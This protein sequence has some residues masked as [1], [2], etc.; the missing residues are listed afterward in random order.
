MIRHEILNQMANQRHLRRLL[1]PRLAY[2]I[3]H[4]RTYSLFALRDLYHLIDLTFGWQW[5]KKYFSIF[6]YQMQK[7]RS[8]VDELLKR[9]PQPEH[10]FFNQD[11]FYETYQLIPH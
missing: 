3:Q 8:N 5:K 10:I 9:L 2:D 7:F 11:N 4:K 1:R 6:N